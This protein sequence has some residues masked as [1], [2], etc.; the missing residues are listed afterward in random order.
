MHWPLGIAFADLPAGAAVSPTSLAHRLI[1][2]PASVPDEPVEEPV[3]E[4]VEQHTKHPAPASE[5]TL[6]S[7]LT[8]VRAKADEARQ[9]RLRATATLYEGLSAAYDFARCAAR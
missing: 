4:A 3:L 6:Q 9:A 2:Y 7:K 1:G 5:G 8:E